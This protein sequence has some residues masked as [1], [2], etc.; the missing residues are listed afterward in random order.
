MPTANVPLQA[1]GGRGC[2]Q[3][4][5]L[6]VRYMRVS[7]ALFAWDHTSRGAVWPGVKTSG[8]YVLTCLAHENNTSNYVRLTA[9]KKFAL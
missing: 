4:C 1:L 3:I 5:E 6:F 7:L 9:A 8:T 2:K